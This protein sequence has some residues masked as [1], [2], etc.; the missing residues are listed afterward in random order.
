MLP[1]KPQIR[2]LWRVMIP[3]MGFTT[4]YILDGIF[5]LAALRI[6]RYNTE[7]RHALL[8]YANERHSASLSKALPLIAMATP[9]SYTRFLSSGS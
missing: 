2:E 6:A 8:P 4:D 1:P 9:Q 3:E 5:A 7:R